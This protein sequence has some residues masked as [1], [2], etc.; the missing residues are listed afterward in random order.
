MARKRQARRCKARRSDGQPCRAYAITGG[1][2]C[3]AHGGRAPRVR[4]EARVRHVRAALRVAFAKADARWRREAEEWQVG[5][6]LAVADL[7]GISPADV[8][9][10]LMGWCVIEY[11]IPGEETMPQIRVDRR[12]GP[13]SRAQLATRAARQAARKAAAADPRATSRNT[14]PGGT[15]PAATR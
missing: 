5:R 13:R 3:A 10:L 2:V 6:I 15:P 1:V 11:G 8:T 14:L 4:Q 12:Y 9:P 7:L